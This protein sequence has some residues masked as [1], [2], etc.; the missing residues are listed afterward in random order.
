MGIKSWWKNTITNYVTKKGWLPLEDIKQIQEADIKKYKRL[1]EYYIWYNANSNILAN[2]YDRYKGETN[3]KS[4]YFWANSYL[5]DIKKT[6]SGLP[7][8]MIDT[9][10]NVT[11]IPEITSEDE[12]VQE[13]LETILEENDFFN[14]IKQEQIPLTL[15]IGDGAFFPNYINGMVSI[16]FVDGR[17]CDIEK[18]GN[19][20]TAITKKTFY[21]DYT[22]Y[23]RRSYNKIEYRLYDKEKLVSLEK[24][25]ETRE[26]KDYEMNIGM[27]P[28]V[29]VRFK[30]GTERYG[31]SIFQGKLDLFDDFDQSWSMLSNN[32]R[33]SSPTTYIPADMLETDRRTGLAIQPDKFGLKVITLKTT[34]PQQKIETVQPQ[35][36]STDL[37]ET[38]NKQLIMIL[39]GTLSPSSLGFELTRTPNA[40]AQREREK[41]TLVSRD[42]I[43]DNEM[44]VLTKL[45]ELVLR[46]DDI[47]QGNNAGEYEIN[48]DFADFAA[49]TFN[50]RVNTLLPILTAAGISIER[51]VEQLWAGGLKGE[52]L[53]E[54]IE[55]VKARQNIDM[56]FE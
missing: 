6:H 21:G 52:A 51:F 25:P 46:F 4:S 1:N 38:I 12:A 49:P 16:D 50:E 27:I 2:Y 29:A 24:L 14:L 8:A 26:L 54:E 43:I 37:L 39:G 10:V 44:A 11:G 15:V 22:L 17:Y 9:L 23:E 7:M 40:E 42:D 34:N 48:V 56:D 19:L 55:A 5:N 47:M 31:R 20:I 33:L 41:V 53:E 18:T 32:V 35:I 28:A 45:C 30:G 36:L 13:R 3:V